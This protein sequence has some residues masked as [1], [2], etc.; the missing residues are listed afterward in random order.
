MSSGD[1]N[2]SETAALGSSQILVAGT[3]S[4]GL[5]RRQGGQQLLVPKVVRIKI[6]EFSLSLR[7]HSCSAHCVI[8]PFW[9]LLDAAA[10]LDM[11]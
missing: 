4:T 9:C 6:E 11:T 10:A 8:G 3:S 5:I 2:S 7:R 1:Q